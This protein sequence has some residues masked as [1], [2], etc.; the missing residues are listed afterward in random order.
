MHVIVDAADRAWNAAQ[1]E[2][3]RKDGAEEF[4]FGFDVDQA[5]TAQRSSD[6]VHIHFRS[7]I[8]D[9]PS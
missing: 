3:L 8:P 9:F 6:E 5:L 4:C 7:G 1:F 2:A